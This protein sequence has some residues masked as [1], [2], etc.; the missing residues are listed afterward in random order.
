MLSV[1][2]GL[3]ATATTIVITATTSV[4]VVGLLGCGCWLCERRHVAKTG[5]DVRVS[6]SVS[7]V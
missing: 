6:A 5:T 7:M 3:S 2:F 4:T 1:M